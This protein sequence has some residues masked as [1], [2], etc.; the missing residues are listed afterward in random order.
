[1]NESRQWTR[2]LISALYEDIS[3]DV[4]QIVKTHLLDFLGCAIYCSARHRNQAVCDLMLSMHPGGACTVI[5]D[6]ARTHILAAAQLNSIHGHGFELDDFHG[7]AFVHPGVVVFP[8]V[9]AAAEANGKS[10]RDF[11]LATVLGY[12]LMIRIG[13]ALTVRH[14]LR[15][16]HPTGTAGAFAA[17]AVYAKLLDYPE[18]ETK[19]ALGIAGSMSSG[20]KQ[21]FKDG[22]SVKRLHPSR[23]VQGGI[24][25]SLL[26]AAGVTGP[27]E[28][29][30][31]EL[32][33]LHAFTDEAILS[34]L[35]DDLGSRWRMTGL[36]LKPFACCGGLHASITGLLEIR[37]AVIAR[38][39]DLTGIEI[40]V[41]QK[42][43]LQNGPFGNNT[44]MKAQYSLPFAAALTLLRDICDPNVFSM[45]N[46]HDESIIALAQK[47]QVYASAD[48]ETMQ[49]ARINVR[50]RDGGS[51]D[52]EVVAPMG[53]PDN[54]LSHG[55]VSAKF[56]R[57]TGGC[58]NSNVAERIEKLVNEMESL[59]NVSQLTRLLTSK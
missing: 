20:I 16:F 15:G 48:I 7:E 51:L 56:Y 53:S 10:G 27:A 6:N 39:D 12:E 42:V 8:V 1:M 52:R 18:D 37:D 28:V 5:G 58:M 47:I 14:N 3:S 34:P 13:L 11:L 59:S 4:L 41:C 57:L 2:F 21:F 26:A 30:E 25:A 31:G 40:E 24:T 35:C 55:D 29:L 49:Q 44:I 45:E 38:I 54:P 46:L 23:A 32:G 36:S 19:N 22:D 50:F 43:A 33:F 17:S 9:L